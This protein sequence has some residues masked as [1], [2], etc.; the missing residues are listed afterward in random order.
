[1][2][3]QQFTFEVTATNVSG[4]NLSASFIGQVAEVEDAKPRLSS[5]EMPTGSSRK[6]PYDLLYID[7]SRYEDG[8]PCWDGKW[9]SDADAAC[10]LPPTSGSLLRLII[11]NDATILAEYRN[12]LRRKRLS[13]PVIRQ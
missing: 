11:N 7:R 6:S 12:A 3:G 10:Y 4:R 1:V 8:I 2:V 9:W 13:E 5:V